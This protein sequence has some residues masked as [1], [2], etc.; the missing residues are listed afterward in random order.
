MAMRVK[1][2]DGRYEI[3]RSKT[4]AAV[5][6]SYSGNVTVEYSKH[7]TLCH[8]TSPCYTMADGSGPC[9]DLDTKG[10]TVTAYTLPPEYFKNEG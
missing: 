2:T 7:T 5:Y 1:N 9:G 6:S 4:F 3:D 10:D 8:N